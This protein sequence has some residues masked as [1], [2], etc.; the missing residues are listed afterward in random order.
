MKTKSVLKIVLSCPSDVAEDRNVFASVIEELN[1]GVA[2]DRNLRLEVYFWKT[3]AYPGFH[4]EGPP[5]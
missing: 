3:H 1:R 4:S 2:D 5:S